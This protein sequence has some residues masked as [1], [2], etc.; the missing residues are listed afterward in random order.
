[1][2][3]I[4]TSGFLPEFAEHLHGLSFTEEHSREERV[5]RDHKAYAVVVLS[6]CAEFS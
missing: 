5:V 3:D 4:Q 1:M 2:C 6:C